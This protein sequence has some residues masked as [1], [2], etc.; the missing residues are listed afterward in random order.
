MSHPDGYFALVLSAE[1]SARLRARFATL[2][3]PIA[4]HCTVRHGTSNAADL[5]AIFG[6]ES[7]G[8]SFSLVVTGFASSPSVEAVV[9]ALVTADGGRLHREFTRNA[10]PHVTTAT[11]GA[12]EPFTANAL[13]EAGF[14]P[15]ED[16]ITLEATLTHV[17]SHLL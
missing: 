8:L 7:L 17:P 16:G 5:P 4:H 6:P 9:V 3:N 14:D 11:D 2:Q 10:I 15:V 1:S 12:A 13:L